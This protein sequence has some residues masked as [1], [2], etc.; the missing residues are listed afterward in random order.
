MG[1]CYKDRS[2]IRFYSMNFA[3]FDTGGGGNHRNLG[4]WPVAKLIEA[5][6][7]VKWKIQTGSVLRVRVIIWTSAD[8][9]NCQ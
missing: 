8:T 1:R 3:L 4:S 9:E 5:G 2:T 7:A 6:C